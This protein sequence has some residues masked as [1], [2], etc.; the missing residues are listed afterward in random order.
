MTLCLSVCVCVC[1]CPSVTSRCPI[2]TAQ[3][4]ELVFGLG[5]SLDLSYTVLGG[6]SGISKNSGTSLWNVAPNSGLR[7]FR[8]DRSIIEICY[9]ISSKKVDAQSVINWTFVGQLRCQ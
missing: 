9:Q 4:I 7:K 8:D 6:N 5:A 3:R 1:V 2:E